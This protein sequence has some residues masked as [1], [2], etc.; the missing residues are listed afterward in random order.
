MLDVG[1]LCCVLTFLLLEV[2]LLL[3][4]IFLIVVGEMSKLSCELVLDNL[5]LF[6]VVAD[7]IIRVIDVLR[8]ELEDVKVV[9]LALFDVQLNDSIVAKMLF[10]HLRC[11]TLGVDVGRIVVRR[12]SLDV[13][14]ACGLDILREEAAQSDVL[15]S[16]VE[17]KLVA[18]AQGRCAVR[19]DANRG[20]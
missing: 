17:A 1:L 13:D 2:L 15:R 16:L 6:L 7:V 5:S 11:D 3:L 20:C 18:E 9:D 4:I 12:C 10:Q 19:E 8:S 14:K